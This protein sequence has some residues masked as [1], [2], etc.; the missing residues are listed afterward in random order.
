MQVQRQRW[1]AGRWAVARRYVGPLLR[2]AWR[3]PSLLAL[4][5]ALY[6]SAPPRS[7]VLGLWSVLALLALTGISGSIWPAWLWLE[8]LGLFGVYVGVALWLDG[9][10]W[11]DAWHVLAGVKALPG[12]IWMMIR[13][14]GHA[15][16]GRP[17]RWVPT[18]H[19][20]ER[21]HSP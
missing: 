1:V 3:A 9:A 2:Q 19:G 13:A 14:L 5:T 16:R 4:D 15:L 20:H 6:L 18:P 7:L 12:F 11:R 21:T 8:L 10:T 17:V